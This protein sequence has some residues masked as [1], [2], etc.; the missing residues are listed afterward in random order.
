MLDRLGCK[1]V[2]ILC[3]GLLSIGL[4]LVPLGGNYVH[5]IF[6]VIIMGIGNGLGSGINMTLGADFSPEY[7][8]SNFLGIWRLIGDSG[9]FSGPLLISAI[10]EIFVLSTAFYI[11]VITG[12]IG[13]F[14]F[15]TKLKETLI[16][17]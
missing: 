6:A 15:L 7:Q 1:P 5:L 11:L 13:T 3:L 4:L 17:K 16:R 14:I 10:T 8:P 2:A 9:S 12:F